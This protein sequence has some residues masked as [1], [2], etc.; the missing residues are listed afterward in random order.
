MP[1]DLFSNYLS[2]LKKESELD[3]DSLNFCEI[4]DV[5]ARSETLSLWLELHPQFRAPPILHF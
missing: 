1:F 4:T 2:Y 3:R 5:Q